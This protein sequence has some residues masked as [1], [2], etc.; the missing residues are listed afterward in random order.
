[1]DKGKDE[2]IPIVLEATVHNVQIRV[3]SNNGV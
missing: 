3:K 2:L 1:M